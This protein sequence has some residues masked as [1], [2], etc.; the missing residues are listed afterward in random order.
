MHKPAEVDSH[1]QKVSEAQLPA[2]Q[3]LESHQHFKGKRG[4]SAPQTFMQ[5][6]AAHM[7]QG[8]QKQINLFSLHASCN[9]NVPT[10][11]GQHCQR[12]S[13]DM[14]VGLSAASNDHA[15][16]HRNKGHVGRHV[17]T[18]TLIR[19]QSIAKLS[20]GRQSKAFACT[21]QKPHLQHIRLGMSWESY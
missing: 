6:C 19:R 7:H 9:P 17:F 2:T 15:H 21:S 5:Q 13:Q 10:C 8:V 14:E 1:H 18:C 3:M 4:T 12:E 16:H 20:P 11:N